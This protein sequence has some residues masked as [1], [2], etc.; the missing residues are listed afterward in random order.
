M[1]DN[2][3]VKE[4]EKNAEE[5]LKSNEISESPKMLETAKYGRNYHLNKAMA[6]QGM[7]LFNTAVSHFSEI[8]KRRRKKVWMDKF[9]LRVA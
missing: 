9:F 2:S 6:V 3:S 7:H 1:E 4:E 8:L 5:S